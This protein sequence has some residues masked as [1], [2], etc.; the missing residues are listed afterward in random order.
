MIASIQTLL[1]LSLTIGVYLLAE[2]LYHR[3]GRTALL[4]PVIVSIFS[5]MGV[6]TLIGWDYPQYRDDTRLIHFLLGPATVALAVPLHENMALIRKM[7]VPLLLACVSGAIVASASAVFLADWLTGDRLL[8]LSM[9]AKSVTTPIAIGMAEGL[10]GS[11]S[12]AAGL[13]LLAGAVG[14]GLLP[15]LMRL[16]RLDDHALHG[17]VMGLTAHGFGTAQAF[18]KSVTCGAFAGLSMS[19]TGVV[20]A[21]VVPPLVPFWLVG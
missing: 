19:L 12:L 16:C 8:A 21:F 9:S 7:A 11:G 4:H 6:I 13:V 17:F 10:G 15:G 2:Q 14:T 18:E 20:S 1:A 5:L 3:A